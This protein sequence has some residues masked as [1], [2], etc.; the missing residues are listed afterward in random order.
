MWLF[1]AYMWFH[2]LKGCLYVRES[3]FIHLGVIICSIW[4]Y[5]L[6][7]IYTLRISEIFVMSF[8]LPHRIYTYIIVHTLGIVTWPWGPQMKTFCC[9]LG[10]KCSSVNIHHFMA[11]HSGSWLSPFICKPLLRE[12]KFRILEKSSPYCLLKICGV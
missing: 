1:I 4:K 8:Y 10:L 6:Y 9:K 5:N 2:A 12:E 3:F 11:E 7:D